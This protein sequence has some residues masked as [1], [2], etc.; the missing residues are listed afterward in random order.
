MGKLFI[1]PTP[2]G[3]LGDITM[4]AVEV[5]RSVDVILAED[6]RTSS[7][8]LK[9]LDIKKPLKSYH[10]FNEHAATESIAR[11]IEQGC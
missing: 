5:L 4:R 7:V 6:T 11:T 1:V 8:L 2:V 9:H 3:N 10:K